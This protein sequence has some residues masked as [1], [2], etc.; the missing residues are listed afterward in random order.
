M[1]K[2]SLMFSIAGLLA[3]GMGGAHAATNSA[4]TV[5]FLGEIVETTCKVDTSSQNLEVKLPKIASSQL[6]D[7]GSTAALTPFS[8]KLTG[9][10]ASKDPNTA[11]QV[12]VMF[13]AS[14]NVNV[15]SGRL[16]N[17]ANPKSNV[18]ISILDADHKDIL[19]GTGASSY[20]YVN[21]DANNGATLQYFAQ[22]Y[23][24]GKVLPGKVQTNVTYSIVYP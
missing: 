6:P 7:S 2:I 1:K 21:T 23:A 5:T 9:C 24:T 17:T 19:I 18:E 15:N 10:T 11:V 4:G 20:R 12:G 22:Y 13:D 8:L 14:Q 16:I 3:Y